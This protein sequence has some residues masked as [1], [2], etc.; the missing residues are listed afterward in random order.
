MPACGRKEGDVL[1]VKAEIGHREALIAARPDLYFVTPHHQESR[2]VLVRL[3]AGDRDELADLLAD[4]WHLVAPRRLA[5]SLA[6]G[7]E[8]G[9]SRVDP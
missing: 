9:E 7:R 1:V 6:G 3:A 5:T 4:A 2:Y 8:R